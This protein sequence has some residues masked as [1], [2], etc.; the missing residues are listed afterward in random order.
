MKQLSAS[1]SLALSLRHSAFAA[2]HASLA[3]LLVVLGGC[4]APDGGPSGSHANLRLTGTESPSDSRAMHDAW[5]FRPFHAASQYSEDAVLAQLPADQLGIDFVHAWDPPARFADRINSYAIGVGTAIGDIDGDH[6]PDVYF[7][8]QS[9]GGQL[10]KNLGDWKFA[11]V[12]KVSGLDLDG[13]W[14]TGVTMADIDNDGDLDLY[15]CAFGQPN[16]LYI[17]DGAGAFREKASE[18]GLAFEGA[19]VAGVFADYDNDGL[20][21]MYLLTNHFPLLE[22]VRMPVERNFDGTPRLPRKYEQYRYIMNP[23]RGVAKPRVVEGAQYDKL[24]QNRGDRGFVDVT[25][26]SG[27]GEFNYH[28]LSATWFDY[29]HDGDQDLYVANDF[30]GPDQ[31]SPKKCA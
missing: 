22:Q 17:N 28:G 7:A 29:D 27:I 21:D 15:L 24:Y 12:T 2:L 30:F 4:G 20:L 3:A 11:N 10:Y 14:G 19:S 8:C 25:K 23:P 13:F 16:R 18:F 26:K 9:K 5:K 6:L 1:H 31:I